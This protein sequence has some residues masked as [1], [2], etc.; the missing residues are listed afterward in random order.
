MPV[1]AVLITTPSI[2]FTTLLGLTHETLDRNIAG[3]ADSSHRKMVDAEKYLT[4]LAAL[5]SVEAIITPDLLAHVS[6]SVLIIAD[7]LD[8]LDILGRTGMSFVVAETT[9]SGVSIAVATGTLRQWKE[10]VI[11]GTSEAAAS[12]TRTCY[13]KILL[14]FDRA[15]LTSVWS[16]YQR[17][18][19]R[20]GFLLASK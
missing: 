14:L 19:D 12:V 11:S 8:L 7:E 15:G 9:V 10:A 2:D 13:S 18:T 1:E 20:S 17:S 16:D 3:A 4:C 5:K 6:F